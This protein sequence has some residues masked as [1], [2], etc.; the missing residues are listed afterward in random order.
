[1]PCKDCNCVVCLKDCFTVIPVFSSNTGR[2]GCT[3]PLS[4][5]SARQKNAKYRN[6]SR[7]FAAKNRKSKRWKPQ[8]IAAGLRWRLAPE[9]FESSALI[10]YSGYYWETFEW[11][12]QNW[13]ISCMNNADS[14][15]RNGYRQ[16]SRS[17][18]IQH[19]ISILKEKWVFMNPLTKRSHIVK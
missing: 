7:V 10:E 14:S 11:K 3:R 6:F 17:S 1:M 2:V 19:T 12:S 5:F 16:L 8:V 4:G 15:S 18:P 9:T 13:R